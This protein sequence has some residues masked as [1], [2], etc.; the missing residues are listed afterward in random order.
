MAAEDD[1]ASVRSS[2]LIVAQTGDASDLDV[3][4]RNLARLKAASLSNEMPA[5]EK[6]CSECEELIE[7][8]SLTG[9]ISPGAAYAALDVVARIEAAVWDVPMRNEDFLADI[10][11]FIESSF[12][13]LMPQKGHVAEPAIEEFEIDEV[14]GRVLLGQESV[15]MPA[16]DAAALERMLEKLGGR[17]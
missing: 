16:V 12:D 10:A 14:A 1:L 5:I 4:R 13:D 7:Q 2:L 9:K 17:R 3:P 15:L 11:G 6:L 8:F